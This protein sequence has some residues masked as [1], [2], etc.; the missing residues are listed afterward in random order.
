[1]PRYVAFLRRV[2]LMNAKMAALR[3]CVESLG[4]RQNLQEAGR[5]G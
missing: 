4:T 1:M 2:S 3:E 5:K